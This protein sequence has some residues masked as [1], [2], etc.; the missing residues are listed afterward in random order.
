[1][2]WWNIYRPISQNKNYQQRLC[3]DSKMFPVENSIKVWINATGLCKSIP[4]IPLTS[5][6]LIPTALYN[7][8]CFAHI[9][10]F[11]SKLP[12]VY[13]MEFVL[14]TSLSTAKPSPEVVWFSV[15]FSIVT[16]IV[17]GCLFLAAVAGNALVIATLRRT[18]QFTQTKT[19]NSLVFLLAITDLTNAIL[20]LPFVLVCVGHRGQWVL[21]DAM[22]QIT[23]FVYIFLTTTT[24]N[25]LSMISFNR[26]QVVQ[27]PNVHERVTRVRTLRMG[28]YSLGLGLI[29]ATS[30]VVPWGTIGFETGTDI[31]CVPIWDDTPRSITNQLF[32][33]ILG[34]FLPLITML[35]TY[36]KIVSIVK[37]R[38]RKVTPVEGTVAADVVFHISSDNQRNQPR[39][40]TIFADRRWS[41]L[42]NRGL[43]M[44]VEDLFLVF[45]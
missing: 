16:G 21:G 26:Y 3:H 7:F 4:T 15:A 1:M 25:I 45:I 23:G 9:E 44:W 10:T 12:A 34:F 18:W 8:L 30:L 6:W 39:R 42:P 24:N 29:V 17:V 43:V 37:F 22:C 11:E 13:T 33:S 35:A 31:M 36:F 28:A 20:V 14:S 19:S 2:D 32:V 5:T 41:I 40:S 27:R 38:S